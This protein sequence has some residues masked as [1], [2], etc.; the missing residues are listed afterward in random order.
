MK[1]RG[2]GKLTALTNPGG[3]P[4]TFDIDNKFTYTAQVG[5]AMNF[6]EKWFADVTANNGNAVLVAADSILGD[7]TVSGT[8]VGLNAIAGDI[9]AAAGRA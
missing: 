6:N 3:N 8:A 1:A 2:S 4:T 5:V 7:S 9:G